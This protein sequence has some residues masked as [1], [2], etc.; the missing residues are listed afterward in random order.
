MPSPNPA[1]AAAT[2]PPVATTAARPPGA[3]AVADELS[4]EAEARTLEEKLKLHK[5][6][7]AYFKKVNTLIKKLASDLSDVDIANA[8]LQAKGMG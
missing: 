5:V 2:E 8:R 4:P 1:G 3:T 6:L 7:S